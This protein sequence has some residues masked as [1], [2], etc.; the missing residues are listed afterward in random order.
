MVQFG[1]VL[2]LVLGAVLVVYLAANRRRVL[3]TPWLR[4]FV[5]PV[6]LLAAAWGL[7]VAEDLGAGAAAPVLGAIEPA[8]GGTGPV[9]AALNLAEHV[10]LAAA[11][12]AFAL[13]VR[14]L[15]EAPREG[16]A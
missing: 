15:P 11:A 10:L 1:E 4:P 7:T 13:G 6:L 9:A 12:V 16:P 2:T 5:L 8:P 14:R 3:Q